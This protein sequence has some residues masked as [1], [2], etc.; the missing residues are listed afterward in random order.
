MPNKIADYGI[1]LKKLI[2]LAF[3][4]LFPPLTWSATLFDPELEWRTL[5]T[6]HFYIHFHQGE[7][8]ISLRAA[9][10]AEEIHRELVPLMEWEPSGRTHLVLTDNTDF[11]NGT[12]TPFPYNTIFVFIGAPFPESS[13]N[14]Y[15]D[16]LRM[17]II[18][19]YAH[20]LHLD[21]V[22]RLSKGLQRLL[23]R[24]YFPNFFKPLWLIEGYSTYQETSLTTRGRGRGSYF[25]MILRSAALEDKLNTL[26]QGSG[27]IATWP[28][29]LFPYLYGVMFY[30]YLAEEYGEEKLAEISHTYCNRI[31]PFYLNASFRKVLG[32]DLYQLWREWESGLKN[33]YERQLDLIQEKGI[34]P[35]RRLTHRGYVIRGPRYSPDGSLIVYSDTNARE[36]PSL[37]LINDDGTGDR[38]LIPRNTDTTCSFSPDG[39]NILFSQAE[40]YQNFSTYSDLYRYDLDRKRLKRLTSGKRLH[41]PELSPDGEKILAVAS[42]LGQT[43][44]ITVGPD[45]G[46]I[47]YLTRTTE[48]QYSAPRWSPKGDMIAVSIWHPGGYQDIHIL[49]YDGSKEIRV[50]QDRALNLFPTWSPDGKYLLFS[51]DRSGVANLYAYCRESQTLWQITNLVGGAFESTVSP[52]GKKIVFTGYSAEG[53]DL[54]QMDFD[55]DEWDEVEQSPEPL[56]SPVKIKGGFYPSRP[57]RPF[58]TLIPRFW[59]PLLG[60]D[61]LGVQAGFLTF[62]S[63]VLKEHTYSVELLYGTQSHRP[64]YRLFYQNDQLLPTIFAEFI[65]LPVLFD[66]YRD[67]AGEEKEYWE[68]RLRG[69]FGISFSIFEYRSTD[70]IS[71][72][73][74]WEGLS[75]ITEL[76]DYIISPETG[77]FSGPRV[78]WSYSSAR[79]Y[80]LSV[81]PEDGRSISVE[82]EFLHE[83]YGSDFNIRKIIADYREYLGLPFDNHIL[84]LRLTGGAA[85]GEL[86]RRRAFRLGGYS[87]SETLLGI[88]DIDFYLRGYPADIFRGQRICLTSLEYRLPLWI[89]ERGLG[90]LPV[91]FDKL[92]FRLF[93]DWGNAWDVTTDLSDFKTGVG[94]EIL[95]DLT[96]GYHLPLSGRLG[97]ARGLDKEGISEF[98]FQ[99]GSSF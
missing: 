63:D 16:W 87:G 24:L 17:V 89:P 90:T 48:L 95:V 39:K 42:G 43:N 29:G 82:Y 60:I 25:D 54:Y 22:H 66:T 64:A 26:D 23:G 44:L 15:D 11:A 86:L 69:S 85:F 1:L 80:G 73:Y 27:V 70:R 47:T 76:P 10:I 91:F 18:H 38:K 41:Y 65:D 45:G 21:Q 7:E 4:T 53:F 62:G 74:T 71:L 83:A 40:I 34:T 20:I 5:E 59:I 31:I 77:T 28:G 97:W 32:K 35:V 37:R 93:A 75:A 98:Y 78:G 52:D 72:A 36:Y 33:K 8:E 49:N 99:F 46:E 81:S 67:R 55:P 61:N 79:K 96:L 92:H 94:T 56:L 3:F 58:S 13:I 30:Q 50:T 84:A 14:N 2:F 6:P 12:A 57:Y 51:S 68:R 19:E 9:N 88:D